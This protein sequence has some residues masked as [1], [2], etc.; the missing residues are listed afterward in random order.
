MTRYLLD[1]NIVCEV[2]RPR[3]SSAVV[4]W[5]GR[6]LDEDL[7]ISVLTLAEIER[8]ILEKGPGRKRTELERWFA[9][10]EGPRALFRNRVLPFEERAAT[11]W[12]RIMAHGTALGRPRSALD[13][14]IAATA[15]A[16]RCV[17]VTLNARHFEG[18]VDFIDL[19]HPAT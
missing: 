15:E 1:T 7:F 10:P 14:L 9:G 8:G 13:M 6:Q 18:V 19:R 11:R 16:N 12:A 4:A 3:P 17:V 2:T 5:L